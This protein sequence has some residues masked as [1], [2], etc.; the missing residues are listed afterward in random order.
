M[1]PIVQIQTFDWEALEHLDLA[2]DVW[3]LVGFHSWLSIFEVDEPVYWELTLEVLSTFETDSAMVCLR[4]LRWVNFQVHE[5]CH[6]ISH[7]DFLVFFGVY[8]HGFASR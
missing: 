5:Q 6:S 4:W 3:R 2:D 8:E 1:K 7:A